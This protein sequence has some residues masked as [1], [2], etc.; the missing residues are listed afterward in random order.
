MKNRTPQKDYKNANFKNIKSYSP[1]KITVTQKEVKD[2]VCG[3]TA[4]IQTT[5][6]EA[7]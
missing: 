1:S 3:R 7:Q 6:L 4:R 5:A 2:L